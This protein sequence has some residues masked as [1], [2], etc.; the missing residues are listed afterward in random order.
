MRYSLF[1]AAYVAFRTLSK[2]AAAWHAAV[3]IALSLFCAIIIVKLD[4]QVRIPYLVYFSPVVIALIYGIAFTAMRYRRV[5]SQFPAL[6]REMRE[7]RMLELRYGGYA[8][9]KFRMMTHLRVTLPVGGVMLVG[10]IFIARLYPR[11]R[12]WRET[13]LIVLLVVA[14]MAMYAILARW[15]EKFR[16]LNLEQLCPRCGYD[17]SGSPQRCP[18]CGMRRMKPGD[19]DTDADIDGW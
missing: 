8:L 16:P 18:E 10:M 4:S 2:E 13:V 9:R 17:L 1:R 14:G 15:N 5:W 6:R 19:V 3:A 12:N 7:Q 11:Q